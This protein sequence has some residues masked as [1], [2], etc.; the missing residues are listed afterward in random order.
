LTSNLVAAFKLPFRF[1]CINL[2]RYPPN[3]VIRVTL[4]EVTYYSYGTTL[5]TFRFHKWFLI[6]VIITSLRGVYEACCVFVK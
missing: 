4:A 1:I 6:N 3:S 2:P 5:A